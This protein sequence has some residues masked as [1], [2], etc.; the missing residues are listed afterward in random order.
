[1]QFDLKG[2]QMSKPTTKPKPKTPPTEALENIENDLRRAS[3]SARKMAK[4]VDAMRSELFRTRER[5]ITS[6]Q[7]EQAT[8][9]IWAY[10]RDNTQ[11]LDSE[12][13]C[14]VVRTLVEDA[15]S[16]V[17][18]RLEAMTVKLSAAKQSAAEQKA[19]SSREITEL[20]RRLRVKQPS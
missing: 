9:G 16:V 8:W 13:H 20:K 11:T 10:V 15:V 2:T 14:N 7:I 17:Q 6:R 18:G 4:E 5:V 19:E 1:M 3:G 12:R